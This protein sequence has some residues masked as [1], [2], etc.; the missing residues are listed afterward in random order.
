V[1]DGQRMRRREP[2]GEAL[3]AALA[4]AIGYVVVT[5]IVVWLLLGYVPG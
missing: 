2:E 4:Q 3:A 5:A 1:R